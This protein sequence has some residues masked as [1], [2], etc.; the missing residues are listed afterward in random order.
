M[1]QRGKIRRR[2]LLVEA[3]LSSDSIAQAA[4][5]VGIA[6]STALRWL[7]NEDFRRQFAR[8]KEDRLRVAGAILARNAAKAALTL[9]E[10]LSSKPQPHQG[11]RV[12]A[13]RAVLELSIDAFLA[14]NLAERI[15][16]LEGQG[17]DTPIV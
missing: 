12:A 13:C 14:E 6:K 5:Q 7:Q 16:R 17:R 11:A 3:L 4:E 15:S 9:E 2:G 10:I 8:A 1:P